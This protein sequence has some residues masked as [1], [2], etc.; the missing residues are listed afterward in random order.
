MRGRVDEVMLSIHCLFLLSKREDGGQDAIL[1]LSSPLSCFFD[2]GTGTPSKI[3]ILPKS[4]TYRPPTSNPPPTA[5]NPRPT[6]RQQHNLSKG[7][8]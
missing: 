5:S 3:L 6:S 4:P 2:K 1:L 8:W 7:R